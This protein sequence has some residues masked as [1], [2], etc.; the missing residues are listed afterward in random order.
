MK[1]KVVPTMS[2]FTPQQQW[3]KY[4]A[5]PE[6]DMYD[7]SPYL[8]DIAQGNVLEI[9]VREGV[10]TAAFLMGMTDKNEGHLYS[11]DIHDRSSLYD[12]S[13]WT[14]ICGDSRNLPFKFDFKFD[15][16]LIDGNHSYEYA[17]SDL[18]TFAPL[19][20]EGGILLMHDVQPAKDWEARIRAEKWYPVDECRKAWDDFLAAHPTWEHHIKPGITGLGVVVKKSLTST[21]P[22]VTLK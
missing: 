15:V 22:S 10:S 18:N 3:D 11:V 7:Y 6:Q 12:D 17:F 1:R 9:G 8:R 21:K 2:Q 20:K 5:L 19:L 14:F 13:R 4:R 16:V